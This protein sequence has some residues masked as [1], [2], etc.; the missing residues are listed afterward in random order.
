MYLSCIFKNFIS[1]RLG[2]LHV[3][4]DLKQ[5]LILYQIHILTNESSNLIFIYC[6]NKV[7]DSLCMFF[8]C[9]EFTKDKVLA[10][11]MSCLFQLYHQPF[12]NFRY[13]L[14]SFESQTIWLHMCSQTLAPGNGSCRYVCDMK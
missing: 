5:A 14:F 4:F 8:L 7:E 10:Q 11:S 1:V 6:D 3:A 2:Y 9:M 12:A 13:N